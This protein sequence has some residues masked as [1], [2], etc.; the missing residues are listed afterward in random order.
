MKTSIVNLWRSL[1]RFKS[2][3][4]LNLIGLSVAFASFMIIMM[5]VYQ[6]VTFDTCYPTTKNLYRAEIS[7]APG[8][9]FS[10]ALSRPQSEELFTLSPHIQKGAFCSFDGPTMMFDPAQGASSALKANVLSASDDFPEVLGLELVSGSFENFNTSA[11]A[12]IAAS[13]AERIFGSHNPIGQN[14]IFQSWTEKDTVEVVA[15]YR[16]LPRNCSFQ[17]GLIVH[18]GQRD[19]NAWNN[20]S[21]RTFLLI[22]DPTQVSTISEIA[23]PK[24]AERTNPNTRIPG[25]RYL[26]LTHLPDRYFSPWNADHKKGNRTTLYSLTAVAILIILVAM[27]NFINF[28]MALVPRR[29]RNINT[30]KVLGSSLWSLRLQQLFEAVM[31]N[32]IALVVAF[33]L[34]HWLADSSLAGALDADLQLKSN[35]LIVWLSIG[36]ALLIG[37]LSSIYPA[38]YSTSFAPAMVFKGSF[39]LSAQGRRLRTVLIGFQYVISLGL[40]IVALSIWRQYDYMRHYDIGLARDN[41]LT[42]T[43][44]ST[45]AEHQEALTNRLKENANVLDVAYAYSPITNPQMQW[46]R[47][48]NQESINFTCVPVSYNFPALMGI[49]IEEG[50]DFLPSDNDKNGVFIFNE[51]AKK[52]YGLEVGRRMGN[53]N[54]GDQAAEIVGIARDFNFKPLHYPIED[55]ALMVFGYNPWAPLTTC[56]LKVSGTDIFRTIEEIRQTML[57]FDPDVQNTLEI[58]FF[59]ESIGNMYQKENHQAIQITLFSLLA[60]LISTLGAFGLILFETQYRRKEIAVRKTFGATVTDILAMFNRRY[61]TIVLICFVLAAPIA[62]FISTRWAQNFTYK[63]SFNVWIFL[64]ALA[65]VLLITLTTVTWQSYRS[66]TENPAHAIKQE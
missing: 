55:F 16:D 31:L 47:M 56:Y 61:V 9:V 2:A 3:T 44:S 64:L 50:R 62:Y 15:V 58:S 1:A 35:L 33:G 22:D 23:S 52:H 5:Q 28:S 17:N 14:I 46:G 24:V 25:H 66:A 54:G 60:V 30:R 4:L 11:K 65:I 49:Q 34:V 59:D 19:K 27:I 37:V 39:G 40:I 36:I 7:W 12:L 48:Y 32:L 18:I 51:T 8:E 26:Q 45:M 10:Q 57:E 38:L 21:Y 6:E 63:A 20:H 42:T 43:L 29:I 53:H 13:T 41:I